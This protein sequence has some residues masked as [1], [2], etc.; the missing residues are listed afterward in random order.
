MVTLSGLFTAARI[1]VTYG[2]GF[3]L[4]FLLNRAIEIERHDIVDRHHRVH[5]RS[6]DAAYDFIVIGGG[7]AGAA[8]AA[9]LSEVHEWSVLL[10]EAGPDETFISDVP[11]LFPTLQQSELDWKFVTEPTNHFCLMN[12]NGQ[13]LWPR[14]KVLGGSSVLNAMLYVRGNRK[15]YDHWERLGNPGWGYK[16]V[17]HYFKKSEGTREPH[18]A[19]SHFHGVRG[20]LTVEYFRFVSP[21]MELFMAAAD[22]LGLLNPHGDYNAESQHGFA[23]SQGTL[24]DGLRCSTAK[25]YLRQASHRP[26][27]HVSLH[28]HVQKILIDE[29]RKV[30]YGVVFKKHDWPSRVVYARK[31]VI[32][33]AGAIQSP[34]LLMLSG[35][36]PAHELQKHGIPVIYHSPGV[37]ENLQDHVAMGGGSYLI[38]NPI[39]KDTLSFVIPKLINVE[40]IR[41]FVYDHNG[42]LYAM[43]ACEVMA[44]INSKYQDPHE[45]W[46]DIQLFM[47]AYS[48]N[49]DGGIYS[50]RGSGMSH[51]Y[52]SQIYENILYK[53]TFMV[54]PLL[55]RPKSRG[56]IVLK[57]KD[58]HEYPL[59]YPN[60]FDHPHDLNVLIEGAKFGYYHFSRTKMMKMLNA[61]LN[62]FIIPGCSHYSY[63][64]D[65]YWKCMARHYTQ[66]IYHP[67][68][69]CKMGPKYDKWAVV[70][71][72]LRVYGIQGLRVVDASIMPTIVT[73]NTNAPTIMVGEKASDM[74]KEDHLE[75]Y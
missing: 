23:R 29:H 63:L 27:L 67:V 56:R 7:S 16:S 32:L 30:A 74:I 20:P 42:P 70:D 14:G 48:D 45:D 35:I 5:D 37:G 40:A 31:E 49:S 43:P 33:C 2:P 19:H 65:D 64:S 59:I 52:Y 22:E 6:A 13:C 51:D 50:K 58:P 41:E 71:A 68:G 12:D 4:L 47:A 38:Q 25:A 21:L 1:I 54:V 60:Y 34:Q 36:G 10:L 61:T 26:N 46:P 17:L 11:Q 75:Y 69:T 66:T 3:A 73:G 53:D 28:S 44:F 57:S 24:R 9:R 18:F 72:R 8:V 15:D 39:S 55:M 62:S